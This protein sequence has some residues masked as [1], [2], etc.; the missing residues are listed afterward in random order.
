M[1]APVATKLLKSPK[2]ELKVEIYPVREDKRSVVKV[3]I[4]P[5]REDILNALID[6]MDAVCDEI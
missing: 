2:S 5:V 3:E 4:Y 6:E 1:F